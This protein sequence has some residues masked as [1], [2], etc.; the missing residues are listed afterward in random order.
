MP[1]LCV[2][3]LASWLYAFISGMSS[4]VVRAAGG[5]TLFLVASYCFRKMRILNALAVVGIVYLLL[6][7][8]QLFDPSFQLSFL[9]AAA[10]AAFAIPLMEQTTEPL[11]AAVRRFDHLPTIRASN[12]ALPN[13]VS[14]CVS[15]HALFRSGAAFPQRRPN[16]SSCV[17]CC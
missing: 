9:S 17:L 2:A 14:N 4:P 13:G 6:D 5:F 7:P 12:P 16:G 1:A 3:T 10:I 11:R 15:S 8:A